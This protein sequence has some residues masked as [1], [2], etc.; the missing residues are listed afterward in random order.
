MGWWTVQRAASKTALTIRDPA[1]R[2]IWRIGV[3]ERRFRRMRF[4]RREDG[5]FTR[6]EPWMTCISDLAP[7]AVI[8]V[9]DGRDG[10]SLTSWFADRPRLWRDTVEVAEI[11]LH[12]RFRKV[13]H[14]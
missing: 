1:G 8:G 12:A 4:V 3:D 10:R 7:G 11:D 9:I 5:S 2:I 6:V 14:A 13:L